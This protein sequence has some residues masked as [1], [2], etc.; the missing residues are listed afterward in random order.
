[1]MDFL[2]ILLPLLIVGAVFTV[3]YF[4]IRYF[5][6]SALSRMQANEVKRN[7]GKTNNPYILKHLAKVK[8]DMNYDEYMEWMDKNNISSAPIKKAVTKED[9]TAAKKINDLFS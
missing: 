1:M 9:A 3:S 5:A 2:Y 8:N 7:T 6:K 4:G